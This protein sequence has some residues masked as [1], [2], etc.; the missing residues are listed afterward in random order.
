MRPDLVEV[1]FLS[2]ADL[3]TYF[4]MS[5]YSRDD[6]APVVYVEVIEVLLRTFR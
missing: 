4:Q 2:C 6:D 1:V 3:R 5:Q